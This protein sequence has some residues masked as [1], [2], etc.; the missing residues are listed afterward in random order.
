MAEQGRGRAERPGE[1]AG[2]KPVLRLR[3]LRTERLTPRMTRVVC[4]GDG[5][6]AYVPTG[7]TDSYVKVVF[8]VPGVEYPEPFD[9]RTAAAAVPP[10]HRPRQRTYTVRYHDPDAG[11]LALDIVHHGDVG[12]GGPWAARARP[13]DEVFLLGPGG[14]YAPRSDVDAHLFVGDES[15]LPAIAASLEA[16][17]PGTPVRALL[18]V[19]DAAEEQPLATKGAAEI[20]WLHRAAGDDLV[21][22]VRGLALPD[23][24]VQAF[25][26]G[27]AGMVRDL[28][29]HL[30]RE[31]GL[32]PALLSLS[33][34]WRR[35]REDEAWRAEK[36]QFMA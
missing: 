21:E 4:G 25:V 23:G 10:E 7:C 9:P 30:L 14:K 1:R 15:A 8:P 32:D 13:G 31:R 12:L 29:T 16:V 36:A 11:E 28:R 2:G 33:G 6:G 18:L 35:G 27:E 17:D 20:R 19:T 22:A 26:H 34:Y 24:L 3:V 5:L